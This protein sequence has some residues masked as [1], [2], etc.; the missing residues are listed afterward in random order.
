MLFL[1]SDLY[2]PIGGVHMAC[3]NFYK[4]LNTAL[5]IISFYKTACDYWMFIIYLQ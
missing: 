4:L 3:V 5:G 2:I 1:N